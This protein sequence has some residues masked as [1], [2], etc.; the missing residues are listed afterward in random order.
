MK[1]HDRVVLTEDLPGEGLVAGDLGT[2]V[3]VYEDGEAYEV[4]FMTI[5]GDTIA[6]STILADGVRAVAPKEVAHARALA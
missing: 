2:I 5:D 6:V 4:E 3:G 1:E